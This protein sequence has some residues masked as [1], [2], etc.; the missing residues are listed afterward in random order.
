MKNK[1]IQLGTN[2]KLLLLRNRLALKY[3]CVRLMFYAS[4][5]GLKVVYALLPPKVVA[6]ARIFWWQV[7]D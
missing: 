6:Q 2:I 3:V 4:V 7:L 5:L 1:G